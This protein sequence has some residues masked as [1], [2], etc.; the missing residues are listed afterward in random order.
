MLLLLACALPADETAAESPVDAVVE[1]QVFGALRPPIG[2]VAVTACET[3]PNG[4]GCN[5]VS[6]WGL[7]DRTA[8]RST[9]GAEWEYW[10]PEPVWD[11]ECAAISTVASTWCDPACGSG[12]FCNAD[13]ACEAWPGHLSAGPITL[14]GLAQEL[15]LQPADVGGYVLTEEPPE[16]LFDG[17]L[18]RIDAPGAELGAFS[19]AARV[20]AALDA[21]LD[22][23]D[24]IRDDGDVRITW[25]PGEPG[26]RVRLQTAAIGHGGN[27]HS[28]VM[29]ETADDGELVVPTNILG[30]GSASYGFE[31]VLTRFSRAG[32]PLGAGEVRLEVGRRLTCGMLNTGCG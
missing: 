19:V 22:C 13:G 28:E 9:F 16:E 31:A 27:G 6:A 4:C 32:V 24:L 7:Y 3:L 11:G 1:P 29:C 30:V 10:G 23:T 8:P 25:T 5:D 2:V 26:D 21:D 15:V 14:T 18:V 20:P 12:E 17:D